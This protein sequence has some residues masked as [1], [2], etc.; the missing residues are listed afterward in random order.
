MITSR[1]IYRL[2]LGLL[3]CYSG[4]AGASLI[5]GDS[6]GRGIATAGRIDSRAQDGIGIDYLSSK[7]LAQVPVG[8]GSGSSTVY[9]SIGTNDFY[10]GYTTGQYTERLERLEGR[11]HSQGYTEVCYLLPPPMPKRV[12]DGL[13]SIRTA[14][15]GRGCTI[16]LPDHYRAQD[17]IHYTY[18]GYKIIADSL[19]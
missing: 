2:L 8:S 1:Y 18:R 19:K 14:L 17:A 9:V 13:Y 4:T 11:L 10:R 12:E 5:I 15:Q 16:T 6:I 3:L 7:V